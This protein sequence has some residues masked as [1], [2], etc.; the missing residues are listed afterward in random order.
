MYI[1]YFVLD[2]KDQRVILTGVF[3]HTEFS[4]QPPLLGPSHSLISLHT[5]YGQTERNK[6]NS[7]FFCKNNKLE[8]DSQVILVIKHI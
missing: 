2:V 3:M 1:L 5:F 6:E 4:T 8:A 7:T